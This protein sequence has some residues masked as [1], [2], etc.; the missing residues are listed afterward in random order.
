MD[1][2]KQL[3]ISIIKFLKTELESKRLGEDGTEALEVAVQCLENAYVID[4]VNSQNDIDLLR[5]YENAVGSSGTSIG[6]SM[7]PPAASKL[8]P[9]AS[10]VN[11]EM[12]EAKKNEGNDF[13]R[14]EK[15]NEAIASYTNAIDLDPNNAIYYSNRAAAYAKLKDNKNSILDCE[16][17]LRIDPQYSKAY[18]RMGFAHF[19]D[20]NYEKAVAAYENALSLDPANQPYKAQLDLAKGKLNEKLGHNTSH[21]G[22]APGSQPNP[23]NPLAG[24]D[25]NS[26]LANPAVM[27]MATSFM[28]NPQVQNMFANMMGGAGGDGSSANPTPCGNPNEANSQQQTPQPPGA[29]ASGSCPMNPA[30][31]NLGSAFQN[32]D[33]NSVLTATTQFAAQMQQENPA[34]VE[35]L[36]A[37]FQQGSTQNVNPNP[38]DDKKTEP[39]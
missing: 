36:R 13:M 12:A 18:G 5:I 24:M 8:Y 9:D 33:F 19:N 16:K 34:M 38:S 2:R 22:G 11:K 29:T 6:T 20:E 39:K 27:N 30:A 35:N 31:A 4:G 37:Q 10:Q 23:S 28:Q 25:L 3:A 1:I 21:P 26:L 17:A 7:H 14:V 15:F 32:I